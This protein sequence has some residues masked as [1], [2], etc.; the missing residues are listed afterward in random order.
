MIAFGPVPSRRLGKS[1]GINNIPGK[2]CSYNCVYCQ[3]GKTKNLLY[4]RREF[5]KPEDIFG[6]VQDLLIHAKENGENIDFFT[7]V[8][9]GEPTLDINLGSAIDLLKLLDYRVA[10]ITNG[11]LIAQ[12]AVQNDLMKADY[13]SFKIDT[14][15]AGIWHRINRP[16]TH[17]DLTAL[18]D[19]MVHFSA[20]YKG[21]LTTETM[22]V[23][24]VNSK[25]ANIRDVSEFISNL[26]PEKAYIAI[27]TKPTAEANIKIPDESTINKAF[28]IFKEKI[29]HVEYLISYEGNDFGY[30]GDI[31]RDLLSI[32]SVHPMRLESVRQLI[33]KSNSSWQLVKQLVKQ[34]KIKEVEYEGNIFYIRSLP[35]NGMIEERV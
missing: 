13:V 30:S 16:D 24:G 22:V 14:I 26:R 3:V 25:S 21:I 27:P 2:N 33:Y 35:G 32:T 4:Q 19:N 9:S 8:S 31:E 1:L 20:I 34:D 10:V 15:D 17:I 23:D 5:F 11:S 12:Q 7:F 29:K 6:D 28:Q 18:L